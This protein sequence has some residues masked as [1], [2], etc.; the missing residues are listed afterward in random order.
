[1]TLVSQ[2]KQ[3]DLIKEKTVYINNVGEDGKRKGGGE[4]ITK[5]K[6]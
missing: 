2:G 3:L 6:H 4:Q 1:M 5:I